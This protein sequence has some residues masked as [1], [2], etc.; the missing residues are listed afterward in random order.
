MS[1]ARIYEVEDFSTLFYLP[2]SAQ[3]FSGVKP[4]ATDD[5]QFSP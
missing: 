2:L 3:A 5:V 1:A 4:A